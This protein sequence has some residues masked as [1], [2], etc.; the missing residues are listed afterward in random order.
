MLGLG[1]VGAMFVRSLTIF[2][3][4]KGILD[5]LVDIEHGAH[6]AILTLAL[7]LLASIHFEINDVVTGVLG[8]LIIV[9]SFISSVI[10][11]RRK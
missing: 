1:L 5:E 2:F 7:L 3:V 11:N 4:Q 6:W 8:G 10:Y 9:F